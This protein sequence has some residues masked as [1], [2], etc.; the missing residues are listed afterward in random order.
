MRILLF[1][2]AVTAS[3]FIARKMFIP[4]I[5]TG[6]VC[7]VL[8]ETMEL[9][10]KHIEKNKRTCDECFHF[11]RNDLYTKPQYIGFCCHKQIKL[12]SCKIC[13]GFLAKTQKNVMSNG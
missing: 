2:G 13:S 6:T 1:I 5:I 12:D 3:I 4:A 11:I 10:K 8:V 7:V 9:I